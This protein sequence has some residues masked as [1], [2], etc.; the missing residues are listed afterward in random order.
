MSRPREWFHALD[1]ALWTARDDREDEARFLEHALRLRPGSSVLDAPC[2][3]GAVSVHLARRG[4]HVTGVDLRDR[5][6]GAARVRFAA[7]GL[8][9]SFASGDLREI[10]FRGTFD[11]AFNWYGSFG[12]FATDP[13]NADALRR[14]ARAVRPGGRVLVD[15]PNRELILRRFAP[16]AAAGDVSLRRRWNARTARVEEERRLASRPG[17]VWR[18]SVRLFTPSEFRA[19]FDGSGL[20]VESF[21]GHWDGRPWGRGSPRTIVVARR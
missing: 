17:R 5:A 18:V 9:G 11:A 1:D 16:R 21:H 13:E 14:L 2:G 8:D 15:Q 7:E 3:D 20:T 12:Y 10:E 4:I 6:I 19:L